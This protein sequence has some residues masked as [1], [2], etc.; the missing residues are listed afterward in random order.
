MEYLLLNN[1]LSTDVLD[2]LTDLS[3]TI[4]TN[5]L[6]QAKVYSRTKKVE[7]INNDARLSLKASFHNDDIYT[8]VQTY[9]IDVLNTK[10]YVKGWTFCLLQSDINVMFLF[11]S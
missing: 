10:E 4:G 2:N 1:H 11:S 8:L 9:I 3:R 6:K 7:Y 5:I